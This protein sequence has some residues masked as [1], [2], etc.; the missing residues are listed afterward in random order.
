MKPIEKFLYH[1]AAYTVVISAL[2]FIFAKISNIDQLSMSFSR[3]FTILALSL[4]ISGAEFIFTFDRI[5]RYL[6][7][8]I[9]YSVSAVSFTVIF[10]TVRNSSGEFEFRAS[11]IFA[12]LIVFSFVYIVPTVI[13]CAV[14]KPQAKSEIKNKKSKQPYTNRF[15]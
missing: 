11:T 6:Q 13:Y 8:I 1:A 5:P 15:N 12:A 4:V 14:V 9:H 10:L 3:Y 7:H 2:F